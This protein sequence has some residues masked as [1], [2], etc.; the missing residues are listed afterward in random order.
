MG[1]CV[2]CNDDDNE[3]KYAFEKEKEIVELT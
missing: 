3:G 2:F 1:I